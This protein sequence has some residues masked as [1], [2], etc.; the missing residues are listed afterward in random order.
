MKKDIKQLYDRANTIKENASN[1]GVSERVIKYFIKKNDLPRYDDNNTNRT[2]ILYNAI[3][4]LTKEN[5]KP[6]IK[7]IQNII[8][9]SKNTIS[10]YKKY[11]PK[12][13]Q[14]I[15]PTFNIKT[16]QVIK[17]FSFDQSE[18]LYNIIH[19]YNNHL[20][21]D[22]DICYSVG[23]LY[24]KSKNF[25]VPQPLQKFDCY[26]QTK[27]TMQ[28]FDGQPIKQLSDN[29]VDSII[30]DL[31]FII[32][33]PSK[34]N[35]DRSNIIQQRF[36][37]YYPVSQLI[38]SYKHWLN[39]CKRVLKKN[40]RIIMKVQSTVTAGQQLQTEEFV[41]LYAHSINLY[42]LDKFYL[43][44]KQRILS[45]KWTQQKH[46]RKYTSVFFVFVK[47]NKKHFNYFEYL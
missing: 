19:L 1:L 41:W 14:K 43:I 29:S 13:E 24:E 33:T 47:D 11:I 45:G 37:S 38:E 10:K 5:K 22:A 9:W 6:T 2:I 3:E 31:P 18:I 32:A 7:N 28:I 34:S 26:P 8:G 17:N 15:C 12:E 42:C 46:S 21:F 20:P 16:S 35:T 27:D 23:G 36:N 4:Q 30:V 25:Y 39:E 44:G 40:G